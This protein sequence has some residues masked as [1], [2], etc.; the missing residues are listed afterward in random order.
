MFKTKSQEDKMLLAIY[1]A[2]ALG[3]FIM[4]AIKLKHSKTK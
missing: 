3:Y 2:F 1:G 4:F